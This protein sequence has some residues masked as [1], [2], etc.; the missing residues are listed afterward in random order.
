VTFT[1][2]THHHMLPDFFWQANEGDLRCREDIETSPE[3]TESERT[4]VL[5]ATA[6]T[7]I[8]R[9]A[10]LRSRSQTHAS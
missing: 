10:S 1:V 3:L 5:G 2:D 6:M 8:P 7:L 9:L 4:A